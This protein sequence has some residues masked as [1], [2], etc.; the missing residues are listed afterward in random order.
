M[1]H[2]GRP[3]LTRSDDG[4]QVAGEEAE[5]AEEVLARR[6][7]SFRQQVTCWGEPEGHPGPIL[8]RSDP[9]GRR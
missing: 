6:Q 1:S 4:S 2:P 7:G 9:M 5:E 3:I 8:T